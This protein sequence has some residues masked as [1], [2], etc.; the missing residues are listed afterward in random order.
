MIEGREEKEKKGEK[1]KKSL[2]EFNEGELIA[3]LN[4][5]EKQM[6]SS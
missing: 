6:F 5:V 3:W 1:E 2:K 4:A